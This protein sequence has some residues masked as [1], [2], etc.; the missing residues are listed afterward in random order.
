VRSA[1]DDFDAFPAVG[2]IASILLERAIRIARTS[3]GNVQLIE[4]SDSPTLEIVAQHGFAD[5]FLHAFR[6]VSVVDPC[7]CGRVLLTREAVVIDDVME[8]ADFAPFREL[9]RRAG[10]RSVQSTPIKSSGGALYGVVSTHDEHPG[11]PDD[12]QLAE[13]RLIARSA[14]DA[15]TMVRARLSKGESG[16]RP[17]TEGKPRNAA[18]GYP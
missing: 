11:H 12:Q 9:A 17:P 1:L 7:A 4:W 10:F 3:L 16:E 6:A 8:D 14:A 13:L 2:D 15:M 18:R 5:E